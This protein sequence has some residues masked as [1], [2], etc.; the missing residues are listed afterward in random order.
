MT[1]SLYT[2]VMCCCV[3]GASTYTSAGPLGLKQNGVYTLV[4]TPGCTDCPPRTLPTP[5]ILGRSWEENLIVCRLSLSM[6]EVGLLMETWLWIPVL[7]SWLWLG[8]GSSLP[9]CGPLVTS[10]AKVVVNRSG[11]PACQ[12]QIAGGHAGVGVVN[13]GGA[14]LSAPSLVTADFKEFFRLVSGCAVYYSHW[15][16]WCGSSLCFPWD[17]WSRRR[18]L[19]NS[20]LRISCLQPCLLRLRRF[21]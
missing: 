15:S 16:R 2:C 11:A 21:V 1:S 6:L 18:T 12:D 8:T 4:I 13:L 20:C 14:S 10:C 3:I 9:G 5:D 17:M 7:S 19:K